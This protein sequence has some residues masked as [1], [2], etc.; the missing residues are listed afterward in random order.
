MPEAHRA[1]GKG[2]CVLEATIS[3]RSEVREVIVKQS[4]DPVVDHAF[5]DSLRKWRFRP[6]LVGKRLAVPAVYT[7]R[8]N[9]GRGGMGSVTVR[10]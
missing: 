5:A 4:I 7:L 6:A 10:R 1:V 3:C 9:V 2:E 8:I